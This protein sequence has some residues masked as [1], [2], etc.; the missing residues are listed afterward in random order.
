MIPLFFVGNCFCRNLLCRNL[1]NF[2]HLFVGNYFVGNCAVSD[3]AVSDKTLRTVLLK[4]LL[5]SLS[6]AMTKQIS[7]RHKKRRRWVSKCQSSDRT[8]NTAATMTIMHDDGKRTRPKL[9]NSL[10]WHP[11]II[12]RSARSLQ[13][14]INVR[15]S[16]R[17]L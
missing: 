6:I 10:F 1:R 12:H 7:L 8:P 14:S 2:R 5:A 4:R 16:R 17:D 15:R 9:A 13:R 3:K 11:T